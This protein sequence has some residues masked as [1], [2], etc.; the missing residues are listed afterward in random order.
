V[1]EGRRISKEDG[2]EKGKE[3][4]L[5]G[6]RVVENTARASIVACA[7][8]AFDAWYSWVGSNHR[9]PVPQ[10]ENRLR[11]LCEPLRWSTNYYVISISNA[12]LNT[13]PF[14]S[15]SAIVVAMW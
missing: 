9:T 4:R 11:R 15:F 1:G 12:A 10:T 13:L 3:E 7:R 5:S 14:S 2:N 8:Q 6:D